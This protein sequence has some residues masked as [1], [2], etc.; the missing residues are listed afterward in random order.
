MD[1]DFASPRGAADELPSPATGEILVAMP[2]KPAFPGI[3]PD[4]EAPPGI[5]EIPDKFPDLHGKNYDG[6]VGLLCRRSVAQW[7][8]VYLESFYGDAQIRFEWRADDTLEIYD[9]PW[10]LSPEGEP[11][12]IHPD[13]DGRYEIRDVWYPI[14]GSLATELGQRHGAALA[15]LASDQPPRPAPE[16]L[17]YLSDHPGAPK[18][19]RSSIERA[20]SVLRTPR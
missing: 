16:M 6:D 4:D 17:A 12:V 15:I 1:D 9:D 11:R 5:I 20:L 19:M 8:G 14:A 10:G 18:S 2:Y 7:I 3:I 13:A